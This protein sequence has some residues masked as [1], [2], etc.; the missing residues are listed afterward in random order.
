MSL[1][2]DDK[3]MP[4]TYDVAISFVS[5]DEPLALRLREALQP[6]LSVAC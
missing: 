3:R 6:P 5:D 4:D 1:Y 2:F